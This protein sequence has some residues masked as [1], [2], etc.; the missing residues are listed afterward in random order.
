M[1]TLGKYITAINTAIYDFIYMIKYSLDFGEKTE[2]LS[3][4][5]LLLAIH[6]IEK[7][8]SFYPKKEKWGVKK[9]RIWL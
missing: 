7:G 1:N 3:N 6:T 4:T 2:S 9:P 5:N 8:L